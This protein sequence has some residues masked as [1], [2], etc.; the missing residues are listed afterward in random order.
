MKRLL[1]LKVILGACLWLGA[2]SIHLVPA[3]AEQ[4][5]P[6]QLYITMHTAPIDG[7]CPPCMASEKLL[8]EAQLQFRKVLEPEGPW[9]WFMLTNEKGEQ[10]RIN[11][12]LT[13]RDIERIRRGEFP[14]N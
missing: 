14:G 10:R 1:G 3:A 9:P 6:T 7:Y 11:G 4:A 5:A 12:G 13:Q 2:R 8:K